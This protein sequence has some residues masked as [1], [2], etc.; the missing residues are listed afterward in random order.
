MSHRLCEFI[1][2]RFPSEFLREFKHDPQVLWIEPHPLSFAGCE[3]T[4][5]SCQDGG[6]DKKPSCEVH[7]CL[8]K[9][10]RLIFKHLLERSLFE[11]RWQNY[12]SGN[13]KQRLVE[14]FLWH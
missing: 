6:R 9:K 7:M 8:F 1:A 5:F 2:V 3:E 11:R 10:G 14:E 13:L 12:Y 4:S